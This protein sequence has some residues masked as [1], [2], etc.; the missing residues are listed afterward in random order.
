[1][2]QNFY[3]TFDKV[4]TYIEEIGTKKKMP[5][6]QKIAALGVWTVKES[7]ANPAIF[8]DMDNTG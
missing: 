3:N 1:M 8:V 6:L 5:E 7:E 2:F 4:E